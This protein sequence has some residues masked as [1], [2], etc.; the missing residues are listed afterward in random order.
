[1]GRWLSAT[2]TLQTRSDNRVPAAIWAKR[3]KEVDDKGYFELPDGLSIEQV[4]PFLNNEQVER[5]LTLYQRART[6]TL[7]PKHNATNNF[8]DGL[9]AMLSLN[10]SHQYLINRAVEQE[11]KQSLR[12]LDLNTELDSIALLD[13]D[14]QQL[15]TEQELFIIE[16]MSKPHWAESIGRNKHGLYAIPRLSK[17]ETEYYWHPPE[18]IRSG[19]GF[20]YTTIPRSLPA[21]PDWASSIGRDQYGLFAEITYQNITQRLRWINPGTF[22]MGS[23]EDEIDRME[24][25][26][27][28]HEVTLTEGYWLADTTCTQA[29]WEA[30]MGD[31]P[32]QS[33][34][35]ALYPVETV[36]W[37]DV[38]ISLSK[39]VLTIKIPEPGDVRLA[40]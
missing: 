22:M 16:Y 6:L 10:V 40:N 12:V 1:M 5:D 35:G 33:K 26:E 15:E 20:W 24:D 21:K 19:T 3:L 37:E 14:Q 39:S 31:N 25:N 30:V 34:K 29:L 9:S 18:S 36:S 13:I 4:S 32:S 17:S 8:S 11:N 7:K 2:S 28:L 27:T 38:E 23:P